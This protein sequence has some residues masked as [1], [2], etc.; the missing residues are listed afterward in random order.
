M[1]EYRLHL[2]DCLEIL[3]TIPDA[4]VDAVISDPP[5]PEI[6]RPYGRMTEAAWHE[7][8]REVVRQTRRILKPKGSAVFILQPNSRKVGSMRPWLFEFQAWCCREWNIVQDAWWWNFETLPLGGA[9]RHG[10][11]RPSLKACV[12]LGDPDC[13][14]NQ[15]DVLWEE[16]DSNRARRITERF[17]KRVGL[18]RQRST[19][20]GLRDDDRRIANACV[21][22]GGT[23]PFNLIPIGPDGKDGLHK[24][25]GRT[26]LILADWWVRYISP[27]GGVVADWFAG[28]GTMGLAALKHGRSFIGVEKMPEYHA[29]AE[30]RITEAMPLFA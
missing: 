1:P 5:Y 26:P 24:H 17:G 9:N 12:W 10:L 23:T 18:S 19:S 29:I 15:V 25:P 13:R 22:R 2:G 14:R 20:E 30:R 16:S 6:D 4:S 28:S 8:M 3:P 27:A 7:M 21:V 11:M